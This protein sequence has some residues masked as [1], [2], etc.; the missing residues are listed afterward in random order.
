MRQVVLVHCVLYAN[1]KER[2]GY[3]EWGSNNWAHITSPTCPHFFWNWKNVTQHNVMDQLGQMFKI[4]SVIS[5]MAVCSIM[6]QTFLKSDVAFLN[7]GNFIDDIIINQWIVDFEKKK[8]LK[9][10]EFAAVQAIQKFIFKWRNIFFTWSLQH[11]LE[12]T[13][14][15]N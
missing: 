12:S 7:N 13:T 2:C 11:N 14:C 8:N 9:V 15:L 5:Q 1:P 6:V 10:W 4:Y 3:H